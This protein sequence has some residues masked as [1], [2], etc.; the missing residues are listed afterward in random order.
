MT[1]I[2]HVGDFGE[3]SKMSTSEIKAL[4]GA[5][6][7]KEAKDIIANSDDYYCE[8]ICFS[9]SEAKAL[10]SLRKGD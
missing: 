5:K 2:Y 8:C 1:N 6:T 4:T 10:S 3:I 9:Y 7:L